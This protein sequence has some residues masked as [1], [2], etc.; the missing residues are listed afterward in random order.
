MNYKPFQYSGTTNF[1]RCERYYDQPI[2]VLGLPVDSGTSYRSGTRHGPAGIRAASAMLTDGHLAGYDV[3]L[4]PWLGDYGDL[5]LPTGNTQAVLAMIQARMTD[6]TRTNTHVVALGGDHLITL[7]ILRSLK[8]K[9]GKIAV[10]HFDAHCDTWNDHFG[11]THGHGTWLRHA[12]DEDLVQADHTISIGIRSPADEDSRHYLVSKGGITLSAYEATV[13]RPRDMAGLIARRVGNMPAY[14]SLDIDCL[15]PSQAP[16]TGTPEIGGLSS[17]WLREVM[18][19][20]QGISWIGMDCVEVSPA[21]DHAEITS[22]AAATF[23]LQYISKIAM[24]MDTQ[25][26][27]KRLSKPA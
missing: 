14:L 9:H 17:I 10:V 27:L 16:G 7:P 15:D 25:L 24:A 3:D 5:P 2:A 11:E 20:M 6:L 8:E 26:R 23:C 21:Y 22:L 4:Y 1:L 18:D 12:I 19:N 13:V